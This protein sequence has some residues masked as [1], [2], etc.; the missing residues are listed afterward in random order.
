MKKRILL[1]GYY[2]FGNLGDDLLFICNYRL[3]E[4][5]FPACSIDIL[6]ES[7][8]PQY[9]NQLIDKQLNY[10]NSN[11]SGEYEI[12][13]HGGGGVFFDFKE[14]SKRSLW[15]NR[16]IKWVGP[17]KFTMVNIW[18]RRKMRKPYIRFDQR[19]GMGI[20]VGS[21]TSSSNKYR[22][23]IQQLLT[24]DKL[25]VR[26]EESR[27]N[28]LQLYAQINVSSA[29]D[30]VF[31]TDL[32]MSNLQTIS[33]SINSGKRIGIILRDWEFDFNYD[34][35][36]DVLNVIKDL[37]KEGY[38]V[39]CFAFDEKTDKKYIDSFK[40]RGEV[41]TIWN[42]GQTSISDY[43]Q[44]LQQQDLFITSRF[45][46]AIVGACLGKPGICLNIEPK[47]KSAIEM[48]EGCYYL[49]EL[50]IKRSIYKNV[51]NTNDILTSPHK[52]A[53]QI[54]QK[55]EENKSLLKQIYNQI[56]IVTK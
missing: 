39:S 44:L 29:T 26:D 30:I 7:P 9:L 46:G 15:I 35:L 27:K 54:K 50:P 14:G 41:V 1:T 52:Y 49:E 51:I 5:M 24:F 47:L 37:K 42:P 21:F 43:L 16:L 48:L 13:W 56:S 32:W 4:R 38:S 8:T 25:I 53:N 22:N 31:D 55:A 18:W 33:D 6:T 12:I 2:G 23:K 45:H 17:K 10:L 20:G 3:L 40:K 28:A 34:Y 11:S 19:I 36:E